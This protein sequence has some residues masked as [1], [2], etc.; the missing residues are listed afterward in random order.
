MPID[1]LAGSGTVNIKELRL[2]LRLSEQAGDERDREILGEH[3][4]ALIQELKP[5]LV[6]PV[7]LSL[8]GQLTDSLRVVFGDSW[9]DGHLIRIYESGGRNPRK[10]RSGPG[11]NVDPMFQWVIE[12]LKKLGESPPSWMGELYAYAKLKSSVAAIY[13]DVKGMRWYISNREYPG[14]AETA[15]K[16]GWE[17]VLELC[18]ALARDGSELPTNWDPMTSDI[19]DEATKLLRSAD[20]GGSPEHRRALQFVSN[21]ANVRGQDDIDGDWRR[22]IAAFAPK[23]VATA[24]RG[25]FTQKPW[26]SLTQFA[27]R[28][29]DLAQTLARLK[30]CGV[31]ADG[32]VA[33]A[34]ASF[35]TPPP[36]LPR[37]RRF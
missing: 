11:Q 6:S 28:G 13:P 8:I 4:S 22:G 34:G 20:A 1:A 31:G 5:N 10:G 25:A 36:S 24:R 12:T 29:L 17:W 14:L 27:T 15:M 26:L 19:A 16:F 32:S 30:T 33:C 7:L 37:V 21:I 23:L 18:A 35:E 3:F 2:D 9:T